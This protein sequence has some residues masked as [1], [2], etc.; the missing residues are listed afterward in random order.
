[1]TFSKPELKI[2]TSKTEYDEHGVKYKI[3]QTKNIIDF[4]INHPYSNYKEN[5]CWRST[6]WHF[7]FQRSLEIWGSLKKEKIENSLGKLTKEAKMSLNGKLNPGNKLYFDK[8]EN[9][10]W[11]LVLFRNEFGNKIFKPLNEKAIL[12][13]KNRTRKK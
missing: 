2:I 11:F 7:A 4:D 8:N 10:N 1:M 9:Q 6:I 12:E 13:C 5:I 3:M